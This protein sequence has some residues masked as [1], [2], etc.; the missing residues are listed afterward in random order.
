MPTA[1]AKAPIGLFAQLLTQTLA[2]LFCVGVPALVT[3]IAPVSWVSF[4]RDA[5]GVTARV[6]TCL[7][8]IVPFKTAVIQP[9]LA[10][11]EHVLEGSIR[12]KKRIGTDKKYQ[13]ED[14]GFLLIRGPD[15]LAKVQVSP[16]DLTSTL[17]KVETFLAQPEASELKLFVVAN[18]KFSVLGGAL[19]SM[20]TL[21]YFVGVSFGLLRAVLRALGLFKA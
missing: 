20:L 7:L 6:Q 19:V 13:A 4:Q 21:L 1:Q 18:W 2:L 5:S 17:A 3:M 15:Q 9:V 12:I 8:F 11:N 14:E 16:V 10:V